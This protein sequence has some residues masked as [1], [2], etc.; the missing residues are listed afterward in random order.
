MI[1]NKHHEGDDIKSV[2][3]GRMQYAPT[4]VGVIK[5]HLKINIDRRGVL[6]TPYIIN[7]LNDAIGK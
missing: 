6:H 4:M 5:Y 3:I 2:Y 1:E 7:S